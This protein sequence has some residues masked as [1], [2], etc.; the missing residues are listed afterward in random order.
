M[1]P[2]LSRAGAAGTAL[3]VGLAGIILTWLGLFLSPLHLV[4][5]AWLVGISYWTAIAIGF[6]MLTMILHIFDAMWGTVLRRQLKHGLSAFKW[7][8]VLFL[9]LLLLSIFGPRDTIWGWLNPQHLVM[10]QHETVGH[11][12][13]YAKKAGFLNF[14]ALIICTVLFYT[15]WI[16]LSARL[17]F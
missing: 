2:N 10:P 9:P 1:P 7:L 3:T 11:D 14:K 4:A 13:V 15:I 8:A 6:L 5:T 12:V 16:W 17:H